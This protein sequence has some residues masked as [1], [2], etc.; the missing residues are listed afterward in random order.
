M[1]S[2]WQVLIAMFCYLVYNISFHSSFER[3]MGKKR[4]WCQGQKSLGPFV[5]IRK[6]S[7]FHVRVEVLLED[8]WFLLSSIWNS[9]TWPCAKSFFRSRGKVDVQYKYTTEGFTIFSRLCVASLPFV[10]YFN[11]SETDIRKRNLQ[12]CFA[13]LLRILS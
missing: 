11:M 4:S 3:S 5:N 12:P 9:I 7:C 10:V 6:A 13:L 8:L 2:S 1:T